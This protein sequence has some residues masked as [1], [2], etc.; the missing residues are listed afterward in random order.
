[1]QG[2]IHYLAANPDL[3]TRITTQQ[4][5]EQH[6]VQ[7]GRRQGRPTRFKWEAYLAANPDLMAAGLARENEAVDHYLKYGWREKRQTEDISDE[8]TGPNHPEFV[9]HRHDQS[10]LTVVLAKHGVP[11]LSLDNSILQ[12]QF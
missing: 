2:W 7:Q 8:Y 11:L 9:D 6:Y 12:K 4:S 10:L 5:A 1:M 3:L